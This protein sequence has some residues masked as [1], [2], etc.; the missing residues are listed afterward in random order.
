M[1]SDFRRQWASAH[2]GQKI[3]L[4]NLLTYFGITIEES[5]QWR[6]T[7]FDPFQFLKEDRELQASLSELSKKF[8]IICVTNNPVEPARK[9]LEAIGISHL[10]KHIIGLDT[11]Y[12]SK[13]SRDIFQLAVKTASRELNKNLDFSQCISIGDR[14]DIDLALP[15]EMGMGA[16][17]VDSVKDIY[18]LSS[19]I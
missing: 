18:N 1:V 6:K 9:T 14:Y 8:Y 3:S 16:I 13:P 2:N 11:L 4:G 15:L 10:V 17:L 12:K 7:L 5:I 19:I